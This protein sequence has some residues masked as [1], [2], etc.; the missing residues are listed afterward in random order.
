M[1]AGTKMDSLQW[2]NDHWYNVLVRGACSFHSG[3]EVSAVATIVLH[4]AC[5]IQC[6]LLSL[7][8]VALAG[9]GT[10]CAMAITPLYSDLLELAK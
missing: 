7:T 5:Y 2:I 4:C 8:L 9:I 10:G 3:E 6:R 1:A